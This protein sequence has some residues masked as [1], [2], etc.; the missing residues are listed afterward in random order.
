MQTFLHTKT[1]I[2]KHFHRTIFYTHIFLHTRP[3]AHR[4]VYT[5]T[6]LH[7]KKIRTR[8]FLHKQF[9]IYIFLVII[10]IHTKTFI[11]GHV[12]NKEAVIHQKKL[13]TKP[14]KYKNC[15]WEKNIEKA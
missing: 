13:H 5:Q 10:P 15:C 3:F 1:F 2:H 6:L 8:A 11:Y 4:H 7:T 9:Y 12:L 14:F